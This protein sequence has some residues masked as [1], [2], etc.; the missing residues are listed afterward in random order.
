[1]PSRLAPSHSRSW[2]VALRVR[3]RRA[4]VRSSRTEPAQTVF[5]ITGAPAP[6]Y[7]RDLEKMLNYH[8]APLLVLTSLVA[9]SGDVAHIGSG[10]DSGEGGGGAS[11]GPANGGVAA[12]G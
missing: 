3:K 7:Q 10:V 9:C 12:G 11:A 4:R 6:D 8:S 2:R 5:V 1:M